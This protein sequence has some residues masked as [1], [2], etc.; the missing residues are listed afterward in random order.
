MRNQDVPEACM[1]HYSRMIRRDYSLKQHKTVEYY[2]YF[3]DSDLNGEPMARR[4][5]K[6]IN[7]KLNLLLRQSN[8]LNYSSRR[9]L[10]NT[11]IQAHFDYGCTS[12][13]IS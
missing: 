9:F 8:Y 5:L 10:Y 11:L 1:Y 13:L 12:P 7:T 3:L 4:V 2:G 6:E